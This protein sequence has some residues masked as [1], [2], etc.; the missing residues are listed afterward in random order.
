MTDAQVAAKDRNVTRLP[1]EPLR[2]DRLIR[3]GRSTP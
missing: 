3:A 1:T 2:L